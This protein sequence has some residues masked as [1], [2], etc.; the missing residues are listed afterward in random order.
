MC[1]T[2]T[3]HNSTTNFTNKINCKKCLNKAFHFTLDQGW[4]THDTLHATLDVHNL[5]RATLF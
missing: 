2:L 3:I 4:P 1:K 5:D